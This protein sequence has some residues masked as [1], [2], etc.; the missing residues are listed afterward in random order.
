M[1]SNKLMQSLAVRKRLQDLGVVAIPSSALSRTHRQRLLTSGFIRE[2]MKGWYIPSTPD[3]PANEPTAWVAHFWSFAAGYLGQRFGEDWCLGPEQS[4]KLHVGDFTVPRRL[5]ARSPRGGNKPVP[6]L[7]DT[8]LIDLR[9]KMPDPQDI[10]TLDGLRL[11]S[12]A[13]ALIACPPG[14]FAEDPIVA[15]AALA[16]I[17]DASLLVSRLLGGG[18]SVV[19]GRLAG[20]L[21][22]MGR[23]RLA[24]RI[25]AAMRSAGYT[26]NER[27]PFPDRLPAARAGRGG[28]PEVDRLR[29]MWQRLRSPILQS[30]PPSPGPVPHPAAYLEAVETGF[31]VD[32]FHSLSLEGYRVNAELIQRAQTEE[33]VAGPADR[34]ALA[35]RGY[36]LAFQAVKKSIERVLAG[37]DA[38]AVACDQQGVWYRALFA[39]GLAPGLL[40]GAARGGYRHGPGI[41][42]FS[43]AIPP[44]HEVVSELM[45]VFFELL[46]EETEPGVRVVMG[47]FA[48]LY[49]RPYIDGNG[50]IG[51]FLMNVLR[52]AGG[53]PWL[54]IPLSRRV[55]YRA[56]LES[57]RVEANIVPLAN[58]LAGS[59]V[60]SVRG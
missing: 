35:A 41:D 19:A 34:D 25:V 56:A 26:V 49:I 9:L 18:H 20:A 53:Y 7:H 43:M 42:R 31:T 38:G 36:W 5:V 24:E 33:P 51:R 28:S 27:D 54:V 45:R 29:M 16:L 4:L 55:D 39:P 13:A 37:E 8:V 30:F 52:A 46:Q 40:E 32:A 14:S 47:H 10:N 21:R 15:R 23:D 60:D 44:R 3:E 48:F 2:V 58:F 59:L 22:N 1:L 11:M 6:L 12:L 57:A 17:G 50:P